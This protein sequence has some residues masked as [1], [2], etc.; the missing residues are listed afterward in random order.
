MEHS[1]RN[2][3]TS[4]PKPV[5][6]SFM[7]HSNRNGLEC[8]S[9][10]DVEQP[11]LC[12]ISQICSQPGQVCIQAEN[13]NDDFQFSYKL[14]CGGIQYCHG[15]K[16]RNLKHFCCSTDFCN[17]YNI[18]S[19][20]IQSTTTVSHTTRRTTHTTSRTTQTTLTSQQTKPTLET[21]APTQCNYDLI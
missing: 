6:L 14:G 16:K 8:Y 10:D 9:C 18:S 21:V 5:T 11:S 20:T 19:S 3:N 4:K 1:N 13:V 17:K 7:E 12:N 2:G 15:G